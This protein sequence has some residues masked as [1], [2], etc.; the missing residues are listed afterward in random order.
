[1]KNISYISLLTI[2]LLFAQTAEQ[3]KQAK[4]IIIRNGMSEQQVRDAARSRGY[5]DKQINE[6]IKKENSS[7]IKLK[8][9]KT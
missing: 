5:S 1:M 6:A 3:I 8:D 2:G 4:E 9:S 7:K